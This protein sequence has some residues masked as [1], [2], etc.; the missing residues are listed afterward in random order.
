M[1]RKSRTKS[2]RSRNPGNRRAV[3]PPQLRS[4]I[5]IKHR[6]RF[7]STSATAATITAGD[8]KGIAGAVCT[9]ANS[10]LSMIADS[11]KLHS[12]EVWTPPASQGAAATCSLEWVG[13]V[14]GPTSEVS[15]TSVSVSDPAYIK[16]IPPSD[17]SSAFWQGAVANDIVM[18]LTCPVGS[19]IDVVCSHVLADDAAAG[20]TYLVAAGTLGVL[21]YLP[22]DGSTDQYTP[23][24]LN[25]TT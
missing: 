9:V 12:V 1:N 24:S 19:I 18:I 15:D 23:V 4:N 11:F 13:D 16:A 8:L 7:V 25:T 22:L 17:A 14:Y 3:K 5:V 2:K 21:Y 6:Y 20:T 10:T